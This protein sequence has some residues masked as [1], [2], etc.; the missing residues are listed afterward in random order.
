MCGPDGL[1]LIVILLFLL[2]SSPPTKVSVSLLLLS[3]FLFVPLVSILRFYFRTRDHIAAS[4]NGLTYF[5]HAGNPISVSWIQIAGLKPLTLRNRYDVVNH[6]GQRLLTISYELEGIEDLVAIIRKHLQGATQDKHLTYH[7]K[8]PIGT[9]ILWL[10]PIFLATTPFEALTPRAVC[11]MLFLPLGALWA[12]FFEIRRVK[13][14]PQGL[15]IEYVLR[16]VRLPFTEVQ[17]VKTEEE[18]VPEARHTVRIERNGQKPPFKFMWWGSETHMLIK[19]IEDHL[20][21]HG[22]EK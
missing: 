6:Q 11:L 12:L 5:T 14:Y 13:I 1:P 22:Q 9:I 15:I 18:L 8:R 17:G 7:V 21:A 20:R 2:L 4:D 10:S 16:T 3:T 19:S